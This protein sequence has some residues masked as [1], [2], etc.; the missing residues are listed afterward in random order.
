MEMSEVAE[1]EKREDRGEKKKVRKRQRTI[2]DS[3]L[4]GSGE[5][6]VLDSCWLLALLVVS[7]LQVITLEHIGQL[8]RSQ[9]DGPA[10]SL[11]H[12]SSRLELSRKNEHQPHRWNTSSF[13]TTTPHWCHFRAVTVVMCENTF[14]FSS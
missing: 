7:L 5:D 4:V 1:K 2:K 13:S 9:N 3:D 8:L 10:I 14:W 6:A 11:S 12:T